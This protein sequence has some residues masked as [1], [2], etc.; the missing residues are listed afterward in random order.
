MKLGKYKINVLDTGIFALDGGSMFGVVPKVIWAKKY[1]QGDEL[2]R[3]PLAARPLLIQS[4]EKIILIDTGNGDKFSDTFASMYQIDREK[5]SIAFALSKFGLKPNDIT[6]VLLT[7]LHFDHVG[8]ATVLVNGKVQPTFTN[9]KY[10]V[11]KSHF[12]WAKNPT[13][14]DK[15][16][17]IP[18]NYMPL[19][20]DGLLELIDGDV[21]IFPGI[22]AITFNGHTRG[23]QAFLLTHETQTVF[24]P[25][26]FCP[27]SAH[28]PVPYVMGYDNEPLEAIKERKRILPQAYEEGWIVIYEHDAFTQASIINANEKGFFSDSFFNIT[29]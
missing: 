15:A 11:Q 1:N 21:E 7:H 14:K 8:G 29:E 17:F 27:T 10:Y 3:I 25:A 4:D 16:S 26:D 13:E 18:N 24:Y 20:A 5:S 2:N 19:E 28:V 23:M 22:K 6:D 9:A 12:E